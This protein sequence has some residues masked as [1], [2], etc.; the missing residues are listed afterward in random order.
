[1]YARVLVTRLRR[2]V[3][4]TMRTLKLAR[5]GLPIVTVRNRRPWAT[6]TKRPS[7]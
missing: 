1:M 4:A 6:V 5:A 3:S 7:T 2:L